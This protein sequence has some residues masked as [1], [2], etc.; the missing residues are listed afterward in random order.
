ML[1]DRPYY[2]KKNLFFRPLVTL[3]N[4]FRT[5]NLMQVVSWFCWVSG[6]FTISTFR[7]W[8]DL[9]K[10][11]PN[12]AGFCFIQAQRCLRF[13]DWQ[14]GSVY[15]KNKTADMTRKILKYIIYFLLSAAALVSIT[16]FAVY[17][18]YQVTVPKTQKTT[19]GEV[20]VAENGKITGA[21]RT[22]GNFASRYGGLK[23]YFAARFS[24]PFTSHTLWLP[25]RKF[26]NITDFKA[27]TLGIDCS[28]E[29][30]P[31]RFISF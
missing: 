3:F 21:I 12:T 10:F 2:E 9:Q 1:N 19:E 23:V 17:A 22:F 8:K 11:M 5:L 27:D 15:L 14:H 6:W 20:H 28:F 26:N 13:R 4:Y 16:V 25:N 7:I 18:R 24:R 31:E 30:L 29:G